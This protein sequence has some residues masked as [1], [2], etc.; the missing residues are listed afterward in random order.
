[1]TVSSKKL[2]S[3]IGSKVDLANQ[4]TA[5]FQRV[6]TNLKDL[7]FC[8]EFHKRLYG[9]HATGRGP[10]GPWPPPLF[11]YSITFPKRPCFEALY[12]SSTYRTWPLHLAI[13]GV[14]PDY[15]NFKTLVRTLNL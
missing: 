8:S 1:M 12:S 2:V 7:L 15:N 9:A 3:C 6:S 4:S 13:C 11:W 5:K 10:E 14:G